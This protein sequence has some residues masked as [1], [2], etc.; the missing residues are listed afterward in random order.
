MPH[1]GPR[2][3][4][5]ALIEFPDRRFVLIRRRNPPPGWAIPGGFIDEGETADQAAVR[6]AREETGLDVELTE[7]FHVYSDPHRDPRHHTLSVLFLARASGD[8]VGADDAVEA[9]A[10]DANSVPY[11]LAFDHARIL[12][13]YFL[14][15]ATGERPR[16]DPKSGRRIAPGARE[17]LIQL[18]R[19]AIRQTV[20]LADGSPLRSPGGAFDEPAS[21][22]V[23]LRLHGD[24][25]GCIGSF[26]RN[27]GLHD[28][29]RDM[30]LAAAFDDPRF[31]AVTADEAD[32][33]DIEI[34]VLS[35]LRCVPAD[36]IVVGYHGVSISLRG[37]KAVFLPQVA[38]EAGWDRRTLLEETARKAGLGP[39]EW[40]DPEAEI[41]VFTAE[42]FGA[43]S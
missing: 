18:A 1:R 11:D 23:T 31:A 13:D 42:T 12:A 7:L 9:R 26:A 30:A 10:F 39:D 24:L 38:R 6:E 21:A 20:G 8:P 14:Y 3:A 43:G 2:A 28:A 40:R 4:A 29:V 32:L 16:P 41:A 17:H 34:S 35:E 5:D 33:L 15:R 36:A 19:Q 27:H 37:A 22:F 25:R